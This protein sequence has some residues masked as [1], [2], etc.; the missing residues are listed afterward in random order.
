MV[1]SQCMNGCLFR[2]IPKVFEIKITLNCCIVQLPWYSTNNPVAVMADCEDMV[3]IRQ[4]L[5]SGSR[6][7]LEDFQTLL[8]L[9]H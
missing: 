8:P 5:T 7:C 6:C 9:N 2:L 4:I 1:R 3:N